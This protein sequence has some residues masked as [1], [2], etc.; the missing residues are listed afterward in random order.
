MA[1]VLITGGTGYMDRALI[2]ELLRR[3]HA[4]RVASS[5]RAFGYFAP[6]S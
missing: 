4:V 6:F 5:F 1:N 3:G 2:P